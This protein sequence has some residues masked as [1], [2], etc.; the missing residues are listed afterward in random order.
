MVETPTVR[1]V[2]NIA[3][4]VAAYRV[5]MEPRETSVEKPVSASIKK[6]AF[7]LPEKPSIAV[8]PFKNIS[9]DSEQEFLA[10]IEIDPRFAKA[11]HS[12]GYLYS[13]QQRFPEAAAAYRQAIDVQPTPCV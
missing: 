13:E 11:H 8:L 4:P 5:L 2:K 10:A 6:L 9:G 12:L 3:R 7:P 1:S